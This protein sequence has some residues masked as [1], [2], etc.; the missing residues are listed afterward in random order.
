[1]APSKSAGHAAGLRN[2][3]CSGSSNAKRGTGVS[4]VQLSVPPGRLHEG[5]DVVLRR[6]ITRGPQVAQV[7]AAHCGRQR[8]GGVGIGETV[9]TAENQSCGQ[10]G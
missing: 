6:R 5:R 4:W 2:L 3:G 1:M 9:H 7:A 10:F 8:E